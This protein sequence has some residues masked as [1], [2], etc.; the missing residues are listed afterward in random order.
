MFPMM[1]RC[2]IYGKKNCEGPEGW[3]NDDHAPWYDPKGK[4]GK[5]IPGGLVNGYTEQE[6]LDYFHK[7]EGF[8]S[9]AFNKSHSACYAY[10]GVIGA[11]LKKNYPEEYMSAVLNNCKDADTQAFYINCCEQTLNI[12]ILAPDI[13]KSKEGFLPEKEHHSIIY[14]LGG[15]KG[16]G[17]AAVPAIVANAPYKSLEDAYERIPKSS[18]NKKVSESLIKAGA[19]D[20]FNSDRVE[21]LNKLHVLRNDRIKENGKLVR[22]SNGNC[23]IES[24]KKSYDVGVCMKFEEET[25]GCHIT[26]KTWWETL[27]ANEGH[28]FTAKIKSVTEHKQKNG[29]TM[30]FIAVKDIVA[31]FNLECCA[32]SKTYKNI[33]AFVYEREGELIKISG[34]KS[35]KGSFIINDVVPFQTF[36]KKKIE[37]AS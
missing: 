33:I 9:Y 11:Y 28:T 34:K 2:H 21:L 37:V 27:K 16:V 15:V 13:N 4:Y 31:K 32:F 8:S 35:D 3:E 36:A 23:I 24:V 5:E 14:G 10:L 22:D 19:F 7:I 18:F 29:E 17:A 20:S 1:I 30:A 12:K 25:L 6:L 26:H